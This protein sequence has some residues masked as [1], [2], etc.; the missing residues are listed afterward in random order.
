MCVAFINGP[1]GNKDTVAPN[2]LM[3]EQSHHVYTAVTVSAYWDQLNARLVCELSS[4]H[5][6]FKIHPRVL[7]TGL[8][9][10]GHFHSHKHDM[11]QKET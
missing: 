1:P 5:R 9:L 2:P 8:L 6:L 4:R 3:K 11:A 7:H 10:W